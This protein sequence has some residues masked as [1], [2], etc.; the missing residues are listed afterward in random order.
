MLKKNTT[1]TLQNNFFLTYFVMVTFLNLNT[2]KTINH[3]KI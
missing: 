2:F 1:D 3:T